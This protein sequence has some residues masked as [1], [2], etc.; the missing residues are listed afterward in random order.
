VSFRGILNIYFVR[1]FLVF[2]SIIF[3]FCLYRECRIITSYNIN[4]GKQGI[5]QIKLFVCFLWLK[6]VG[7]PFHKYSFFHTLTFIL[8]HVF[9]SYNVCLFVLVMSVKMLTSLQR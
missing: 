7:F 5:M 3:R 6:L 4:I 1:V 8:Q 2:I 9:A